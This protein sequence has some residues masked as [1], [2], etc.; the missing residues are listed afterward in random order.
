VLISESEEPSEWG[1]GQT[2]GM[3]SFW[4][5]NVPE[6]NQ[7]MDVDMDAERAEAGS[8]ADNS[9]EEAMAD[10]KHVKPVT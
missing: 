1:D 7:D 6:T 8:D 4:E 2:D 5:N 10:L 9:G 3:K